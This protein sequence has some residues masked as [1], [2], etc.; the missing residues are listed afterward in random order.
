MAKVL[1]ILEP[2]TYKQAQH[3]PQWQQ[4]MAEE[5]TALERITTWILVEPPL[6]K[7]PIGCRWI[8]KVKYNQDASIDR[9]KARLVAKGFDQMLGID[10]DETFALVAKIK[11]IRIMEMLVTHFGQDIE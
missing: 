4:A 7:K 5:I 8:Y 11:T 1:P 10:F 6:Y 9:Y 2:S 3:S